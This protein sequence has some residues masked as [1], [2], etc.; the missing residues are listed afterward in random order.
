MTDKFTIITNII[1]IICALTIT[2]FIIKKEFFPPSKN[3]NKKTVENWHSLVREKRKLGDP[4]SKIKIISFSDYNCPYCKVMY[5][6]LYDFW[7]N[8]K[9]VYLVF[10]EYPRENNESSFEAS[11]VALCASYQNKYLEYRKIL[12]E[13][14]DLR[15][16][17]EWQQIAELAGIE[18]NIIF[19]KCFNDKLSEKELIDEITIAKN[20]NIKYTPSI[21]INGYLIEGSISKNDLQKIVS[22][23]LLLNN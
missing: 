19:N 2:F 9:D 15:E 13:R 5:S 10:Y 23:I 16:N 12:F 20:Y 21:I 17:K 8:R 18:D 1:L 6:I 22:E 14:S 11:L 3:L 7:K 4:N